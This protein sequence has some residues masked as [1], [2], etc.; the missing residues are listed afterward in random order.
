MN[1]IIYINVKHLLVTY[2]NTNTDIID[3]DTYKILNE[4]FNKIN[5]VNKSLVVF[6]MKGVR[7]SS[8][9]FIDEEQ[10][11]KSALY[12]SFK[13]LINS[14]E[15]VDFIFVNTSNEIGLYLIDKDFKNQN[16]VYVLSFLPLRFFRN[17]GD[18]SFCKLDNL[19]TRWPFRANLAFIED[20][21]EF[22]NFINELISLKIESFIVDKSCI[23]PI[24][25]KD[26]HILNSTPVHVNKYVNLK[27]ILEDFGY[28]SETC[29]LLSELMISKFGIPDFIIASSK[30][31]VSIASG[32]LKYFKTSNI[33]IINQLSPITAL[34]N[35][36][37]IEN[38]VSDARY[39]IV[40]DFHCMGTEVK[41]TKGILW[42]H[43]VNVDENVYT[44]PI[45]STK[46]FDKDFVG[47]FSAHKIFPLYKLDKKFNYKMFTHNSCPAC[48]DIKCDHRNHFKF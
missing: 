32:L 30:N 34:N 17:A 45:A 25:K 2:S 9:A 31:A 7:F 1:K 38:I 24:E 10:P 48:N 41:I 20:E 40:E 28:F 19:K 3:E 14:N 18:D 42:S 44:F 5:F 8:I 22:K 47:G 33:I 43:G 12:F 4:S 11:K 15:S 39:A 29:F 23:K 16:R 26:D 37:N 27:P 46:T 35:Y 6:D 21:K 13:D 36:S